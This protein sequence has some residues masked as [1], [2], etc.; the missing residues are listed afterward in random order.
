[1]GEPLFAADEIEKYVKKGYWRSEMTSDF[2]DRNARDYPNDVALV[3]SKQRLTWSQ[4]KKQMDRIAFGLLESGIG[5]GEVLVVQLFN[6]VELF[7]I[8]LA[9]EKAGII[10]APIALTWRHAEL[11]SIFKGTDTRG[12]IIPWKFNNF[13]YFRTVNEVLHEVPSVKHIFIVG[14]EVPRGAVSIKEM[15]QQPFEEKYPAKHLEKTKFSAFECSSIRPTGGTTGM[16]KFVSEASCT[17][18]FTGRIYLKRTGFSRNSAIG[19]FGRLTG[20]AGDPLAYRGAPQSGGKIVL[21]EHF[22]PESGCQLIE[23]EKLSAVGLVPTILAQ[24]LD[25]EDLGKHDL[26]SLRFIHSSAALLPYG[27]GR[28]AEKKFGVPI[29][30]GYGTTEAASLSLGSVTQSQEVRLGT[31][32]EPLD[33]NELKLLDDDRKEVNPGEIGELVFRG[34]HRTGVFYNDPELT[35]ESWQDG[36]FHVGD[37][38]KFDQDRNLNSCRTQVRCNHSGWPEHLS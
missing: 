11:K 38:G 34:P 25:Y 36:W 20:G 14:D 5:R 18:L 2:C 19:V 33:G 32:G 30:S 12:I 16:P 3:D 6:S 23:K 17:R 35:K 9:C 31:V 27:L 1:M 21:L 7:L 4:A 29:I 24:L 8:R 28:E 10:L 22:T 26:S 15:V 13:D 37:I